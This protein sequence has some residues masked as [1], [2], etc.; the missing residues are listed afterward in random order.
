MKKYK[1]EREILE[2]I[3]G[4]ETATISRA[5]WRHAEHLTVTFYY[6]SHH[7]FDAAYAKMGDGI[8]NLLKTFKVDFSVEMPYHETLTVFWLRTI[9][10]FR[11]TK[12]GCSMVEICNVLIEKFDKDYPLKFYTREYLFS[13][14][15]RKT[16]VAGDL[17]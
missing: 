3:R 13:D 8:F 5:D 17:S 4:F 2:V 9:D 11:K 7:D 1:T 16:F 12:N 10:D 15:A 14:E 6:L